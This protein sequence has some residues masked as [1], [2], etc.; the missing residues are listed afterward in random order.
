[1]AM[2]IWIAGKVGI[3]QARLWMGKS[4]KPIVEGKF[5]CL[6]VLCSHFLCQGC[7]YILFWTD[8]RGFCWQLQKIS[9]LEMDW[10]E[11]FYTAHGWGK[12][13]THAHI[14]NWNKQNGMMRILP[15]KSS[16]ESG[17]RM[18]L[19]PI[20]KSMKHHQ[21]FVYEETDHAVVIIWRLVL[22]ILQCL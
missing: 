22:C 12:Y 6:F 13:N 10:L 16:M 9:M 8:R 17:R 20:S 21:R 1:M 19:D 14:P 11:C 7:S 15:L 3:C 18:R 5:S 2:G 4:T